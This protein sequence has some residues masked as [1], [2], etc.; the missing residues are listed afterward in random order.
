M[1]I[2]PEALAH[3]ILIEVRK[4]G[5]K[6]LANREMQVG[7]DA[8]I[9]LRESSYVDPYVDDEDLHSGVF[10]AAKVF[11]RDDLDA[12]TVLIDGTRVP[13]FPS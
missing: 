8:W 7:R 13:L 2:T 12:H 11:V 6:T 10:L 5:F 1:N 9:I 4:Y 3:R